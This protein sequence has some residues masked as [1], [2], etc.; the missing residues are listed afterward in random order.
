MSKKSRVAWTVV[1]ILLLLGL[2]AIFGTVVKHYRDELKIKGHQVKNLQAQ[3]PKQRTFTEQTEENIELER[4]RNLLSHLKA[5]TVKKGDSLSK[6]AQGYGIGW[7]GIWDLNRKAI[8]DNPNVIEPGLQLYIPVYESKV[9]THIIR[10]GEALSRIAAKSGTTV[11]ALKKANPWVGKREKLPSGWVLVLPEGARPAKA[12]EVSKGTPPLKKAGKPTASAKPAKGVKKAAK[13]AAR[14]GPFVWKVVGGSP[15]NI[16]VRAA[17]RAA[18]KEA[19]RKKLSA[20]KTQELLVKRVRE[21]YAKAVKALNLPEPVKASLAAQVKGAIKDISG[22]KIVWDD[23]CKIRMIGSGERFEQVSFRNFALRSE[24]ITGWRSGRELKAREFTTDYEGMKYALDI[25]EA[26]GNLVWQKEVIPPPQEAP[27][28]PPPAATKPCPPKK[29]M[30]LYPP[31]QEALTAPP[32]LVPHS[33]PPAPPEKKSG[34]EFGSDVNFFGGAFERIQ[35]KG[36]GSYWGTDSDF[37][38]YK[39]QVG[40][41][42]LEVGPS[43][44]YVA[45]QGYDF[46]EKQ[47]DYGYWKGDKW[48]AGGVGI[49]TGSDYQSRLKLRYGQKEADFDEGRF[50]MHDRADMLG[51]EF[52]QVIW[53]PDP[54]RYWFN[55]EELELRGDFDLHGTRNASFGKAKVDLAPDNQSE[56]N[57]CLRTQ[58]YKGKYVSPLVGAE[59]N[60]AEFTDTSHRWTGKPEVGLRVGEGVVDVIGGYW[61]REGGNN[62]AVAI[63]ANVNL[64]KIIENL[65]NLKS[66]TKSPGRC[67][68]EKTC[69]VSGSGTGPAGGEP[70]LSRERTGETGQ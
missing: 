21:V 15:F 13:A 3:L 1:M 7:Y 40:D 19:K 52:R 67:T 2:A 12:A 17:I 23:R 70:R 66:E 22:D 49:Y 54:N 60:Y 56:Y 42:T 31:P 65:I 5:Y 36:S 45:W 63:G 59:L 44:Q 51:A 32:S 14:R 24:V 43:G 37:Y 41:G 57:V 68:D 33:I 28:A 39:S 25:V 53:S 64:S 6:I 18:R 9:A 58:V 10:K 55:E 62:D 4:A 11:E 27:T 46:D 29:L 61:W 8:G 26:C 20:G 48:L 34:L 16:D 30:P 38:L 69:G 47:R 35:G 50:H